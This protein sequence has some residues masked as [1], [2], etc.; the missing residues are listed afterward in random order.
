[1]MNQPHHKEQ[2]DRFARKA[3]KLGLR[4]I[5]KSVYLAEEQ[6]VNNIH[7]RDRSYYKLQEFLDKLIQDLHMNMY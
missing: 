3:R 5:E 4:T 6:I 2:F 1:M 7:W